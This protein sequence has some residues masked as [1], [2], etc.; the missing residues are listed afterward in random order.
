[1]KALNPITFPLWG[2]RLIEASAGTGKTWT[3]A[4]LYVRLILGHADE[5][6]MQDAVDTSPMEQHPGAR[7]PSEILVMTFTRAA[8]RELSD[9]IRQRLMEAARCFREEQEPEKSDHFMHQLLQAYS[10]PQARLLAAWR[11]SAAA[12]AMDDAAI[13]TLDA[14]CQRVLREHA[15]DSGSLFDEEL[16]ASEHALMVQA[17]HDYWRQQVYPLD[18][19]QLEAVFGT[20]PGVEK[21]V[22]D[23]SALMPV[24]SFREVQAISL[25]DCI[26]HANAEREQALLALA[27]G[28]VQRAQDMIDWLDGQ[29]AHHKASWNGNKLRSQYYLPWLG[30]VMRWAQDP[31][32]ENL[33]LTALESARARLCPL[34][35]AQARKGPDIAF[36]LPENFSLFPKMLDAYERLPTV[37]QA[38]RWHAVGHVAQRVEQL[39]RQGGNFGFTDLLQRL[40]QALAGPQ[41][42]VLRARILAQFPVALVDEFQDTSPVQYQVL[43]QLYRVQVNDPA[44]AILLIGDPKQ[45]IYAFR[46][47]DIASYLA[48]RQATE[49][50][51]YVLDTNFRS[52]QALVQAVNNWFDHAEQTYPLKAFRYAHFEQGSWYN[53]LPFQAVKA[54][55]RDEVFQTSEGPQRALQVQF[56][57]E[58]R[59][60]AESRKQFAALCAEQVVKWLNDPGAGFFNAGETSFQALQPADI[61]ILVRDTKEAQVVRRQL[62]QRGVASVYL[63]DKD[64]VYASQEARDL[65]YWLQAVANPSDGRRLRAAWAT[66]LMDLSMQDLQ[67]L[68][69]QDDAFEVRAQVM[70]ELH[71]VWLNQGILAMLRQSLHRFDLPARW[72]GQTDGERRLTNV[73]HL[74]ELLQVASVTLEGEQ[75]LLSWLADQLQSVG[76]QGEEQVLRL[77]SDADLVKVITIHKSKGLEFPI[78]CLPFAC[79]YRKQKRGK[80][81]YIKQE[82][83][84]G[85]GGEVL[86]NYTDEDLAQLDEQRLREDIRLLYVAMTRPRHVLWM[87]FSLFTKQN[88]KESRIQE[89]AAGYLVGGPDVPALSTFSES[90]KAL[91]GGG[92]VMQLTESSEPASF[93]P[94]VTQSQRPALAEPVMFQAHF[95]KR[96]AIGSFS[97]LVKAIATQASA[98]GLPLLQPLRPADDELLAVQET[99]IAEQAA[100]IPQVAEA[101]A[102]WHR[103]GRGALMGNF[104][105]DQLEWLAGEGFALPAPEVA[106][107]ELA[108]E[109]VTSSLS[110]RLFRRC[111]RAGHGAIAPAVV[112]WLSTVVNSPIPPLNVGLCGLNQFLP[113]MEFWL[114]VAGLKART[115]DE[116]CQTHIWPGLPRPDLPDSRLHG[117]LMGFADLV[118]EHDGRYW[119]L[120]YKSNSLGGSA[121]AYTTAALQEAVAHH[122]YDVQAALYVYALHRLLQSRLGETY[123][124]E[125]HLGGALVFFIRG[126]DGPTQGVVHLPPS[127]EVMEGLQSMLEGE[128]RP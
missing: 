61:A 34:G 100:P 43:D 42:D 104:L 18:D 114:P 118:F 105:H 55:G 50:R 67:T 99:E 38:M 76:E 111:E 16:V 128:V 109:D 122:R 97:G 12:E 72:L 80:T 85:L 120:D 14:W 98:P 27:E 35:M 29:I 103:L 26:S 44:S 89:G 45:S 71:Q 10:A 40:H 54:K 107:L 31:L 90:L 73:L 70:R 4:A 66:R 24:N 113:E 127:L 25:Q 69:S 108:E 47:A 30:R 77:E 6:E 48:A 74:A 102:A 8:T 83:L 121:Q 15:F 58:Q 81:P 68:A 125:L 96:W 117:F 57:P 115:L 126:V 21:L 23:V 36:E 75:A 13:H 11:L 101:A 112:Q 110:T 93:T 124:P 5:H 82:D 106:A 19:E 119:V 39:K 53:P 2:S 9:R 33:D 116:L 51:H 91:A 60:E 1:M 32:T 49:G 63:S 28:W 46:G 64:S 123:Q 94:F 95:E 37:A 86:L 92:D 22:A 3:I 56:D 59:S 7:M 65:W 84:L 79:S 87:G 20:W 41:G 52:S 88:A 78:V 62:R 17:A